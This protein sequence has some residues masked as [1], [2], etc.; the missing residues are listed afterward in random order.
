MTY[1]LA[2]L[3]SIDGD[4]LQKCI[5]WSVRHYHTKHGIKP[6]LVLLHPD[7]VNGCKG[8]LEFEHES[9]EAYR[10]QVV[11]D[12]RQRKASFEVRTEE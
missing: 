11:G 1:T 7:V 4:N 10:V 5:L 8:V 6:D 9:G 2:N 12:A 3:Y